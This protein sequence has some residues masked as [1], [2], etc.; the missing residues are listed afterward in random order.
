[1]VIDIG[2]GDGGFVYQSARQFPEK[3]FI[4]IDAN[5]SVLVKLSEKI[6]RKPAQG[7]AANAL[8]VHAA[9]EAL[10]PELNGVAEEVYVHFPW[11]SLL[12][13]VATGDEA[14]LC[15]LRR[16]CAPQARLRIFMSLD[17]ERDRSEIER[18]GLP[19]ISPEFLNSVLRSR[20]DNAGFEMVEVET[21]V[22]IAWTELRTSWAKR[23][24]DNKQRSLIYIGARVVGFQTL[25]CANECNNVK[26]G[27]TNS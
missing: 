8:F 2:T 5:P 26:P 21:R 22:G 14:V 6:H 4:G 18:L 1:M 19:P 12:R 10:P 15:N 24:R 23:L 3:F 25:C 20:Y 17:A 16:I 27:Y 13:A 11:G 7:G 9:A